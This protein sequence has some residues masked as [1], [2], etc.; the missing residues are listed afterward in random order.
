MGRWKKLW[1]VKRERLARQCET[2]PQ[3]RPGKSNTS[4]P[5]ELLR[6]AFDFPGMPP[7]QTA[8]LGLCAACGVGWRAIKSSSGHVSGCA[9]PEQSI[10]EWQSLGLL[11]YRSQNL[12]NS[13]LC[14]GCLLALP[15]IAAHAQKARMFRDSLATVLTSAVREKR[16]LE[17]KAADASMWK[18]SAE[19]ATSSKQTIVR[20]TQ[21]IQSLNQEAEQ[22]QRD[23]AAELTALQDQNTQ[24][25]EEKTQLL[26]ENTK[27]QQQTEDGDKLYSPTQSQDLSCS[28]DMPTSRVPEVLQLL[29][30]CSPA[31]AGA[32]G[33]TVPAIPTIIRW[34]H[35]LVTVRP[36]ISSSTMHVQF[37]AIV[38]TSVA[39]VLPGGCY[40]QP[41]GTAEDSA[42]G[43]KSAL[44]AAAEECRLAGEYDES[45]FNLFGDIKACQLLAAPACYMSDNEAAAQATGKEWLDVQRAASSENELPD[46]E[47]LRATCSI[48]SMCLCEDDF[49]SSVSDWIKQQIGEAADLNEIIGKKDNIQCVALR[50]LAKFFSTTD[51]LWPFSHLRRFAV[52]FK[53]QYPEKKMPQI[54]RCV[55][56]RYHVYFELALPFFALHKPW[57]KYLDEE[58][59]VADDQAGQL[60]T[61]L[62]GYLN[63]A[64]LIA[65]LQL[66]VRLFVTILQPHRVAVKSAVVG[67]HIWDAIPFLKKIRSLLLDWKDDGFPDKKFRYDVFNEFPAILPEVKSYREA[68]KVE[69]DLLEKHSFN[70]DLKE[71]ER[72]ACA[73]FLAKFEKHFGIFFEGGSPEENKITPAIA[74]IFKTTKFDNDIAEVSFGILDRQLKLRSTRVTLPT[75]SAATAISFSKPLTW[76]VKLDDELQN[77]HR[78]TNAIIRFG[79][80]R[81]QALARALRNKFYKDQAAVLKR[82]RAER[83]KRRAAQDE[84]SI[85]T[86]LLQEAALKDLP[87][88]QEDGKARPFEELCQKLGQALDATDF[89]ALKRADSFERKTADQITLRNST[90][91]VEAQKVHLQATQAWQARKELL[92]ARAEER[93]K[94]E[95]QNAAPAKSGKRKRDKRSRRTARNRRRRNSAHVDSV[96]IGEV[97]AM[98]NI[99]PREPNETAEAFQK[100]ADDYPT[101]AWTLGVVVAKDPKGQAEPQLKLQVLVTSDND[102]IKGQYGFA[103]EEEQVVWVYHAGMALEDAQEKL[104]AEVGMTMNGKSSRFRNVKSFKSTFMC[105]KNIFQILNKFGRRMAEKEE[106]GRA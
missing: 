16:L 38:L 89:D 28:Q 97:V 47:R 90:L 91:D 66:H 100:R 93:N 101:S 42:K 26:E 7:K 58:C 8:Y 84:R 57:L 87:K 92:F 30:Q 64:A 51:K 74:A 17:Q 85:I 31:I 75:L 39:R 46:I 45:L 82:S 21:K 54:P 53:D 50:E 65:G 52:W 19:E 27:L 55:G 105:A 76:L 13:K 61:K 36:R 69:I 18:A 83:E 78:T 2:I 1:R 106:G 62:T 41:S 95:S 6:T 77:D 81:S 43:I 80:S 10:T 99:D 104:T 40:T 56:N 73:S 63:S 20:R 3:F 71:I 68:H 49:A 37:L 103:E 94:Q 44:E 48:Y 33:L 96:E 5:W 25:V 11:P 70:I 24:L 34:L 79:V 14:K 32:D 59:K 67:W 60:A 4:Q 88:D 12:A 22:A 35:A 86:Y 98:L 9:I 15:K 72:E 29:L 102:L 23:H